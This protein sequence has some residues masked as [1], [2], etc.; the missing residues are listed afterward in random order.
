MPEEPL[1]RFEKLMLPHLDAAY[2]LARWM[3]RSDQDARDVVQEAFLR[4]F[5][6]FESYDGGSPR[7]WLLATVR[8]TCYTWLRQNRNAAL[9][10]PLE[11]IPE[12]AADSFATEER[13]FQN[14]TEES[15]KKALENLPPEFR[16]IL[17]L[18]ELEGFSY[19]EIG[20]ATGLAIGTVMSR[21]S[22]ARRKLQNLLKENKPGG[23]HGL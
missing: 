15:L 2:N 1:S 21:L 22:R 4:A 14:L 3:T 12:M 9:N 18:R 11:E 7:A 16:E 17:V 23:G 5:K 8:N 13:V 19:K 10:I 6:Y 20:G